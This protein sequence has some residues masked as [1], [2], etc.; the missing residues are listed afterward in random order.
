MKV[1]IKNMVCGRCILVVK[2]E[3]EKLGLNILSIEL[4]EVTL[5]KPISIEEKKKISKQLEPFGFEILDDTNSK[6]IEKIKN[7]LIDLIQNKNNDINVNISDYLKDKLRQDYSKLSNLFSDIEGIS[8][9]K[10]FINLKIEKVKELIVYDE[11]SLTEIANLLNYSSSAHL[12]NQF[13]K[14]TGFSPSYFKKL[15]ENKRIQIDQL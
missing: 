5:S 8:I 3:L 12:S 10:Y 2:S 1:Y 4:G 7:I 13:K 14:V 9:E 11:L 15:K 6:I